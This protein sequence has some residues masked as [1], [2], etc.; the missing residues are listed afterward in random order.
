MRLRLKKVRDI[1]LFH[2]K[3]NMTVRIYL[4]AMAGRSVR[5]PNMPKVI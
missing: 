3:L 2:K 4:D 1:F 5:L